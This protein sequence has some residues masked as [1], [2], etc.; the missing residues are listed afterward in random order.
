MSP[1]IIFNNIESYTIYSILSISTEK[2]C[3]LH[4]A[5]LKTAKFWTGIVVCEVFV[6]VLPM[7]NDQLIMLSKDI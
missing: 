7:Q 6:H 4:A 1:N 2:Q 3:Y 5:A